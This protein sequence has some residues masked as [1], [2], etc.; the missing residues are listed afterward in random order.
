M[1]T[2]APQRTVGGGLDSDR[3]SVRSTDNQQKGRGTDFANSL[4]Y[5]KLELTGEAEYRNVAEGDRRKI[6]TVQ[7]AIDAH[8]EY[9]SNKENATLVLESRECND[10]MVLPYNH[11]ETEGYRDMTYAKLKRAEE[12]LEAKFGGP[13]IP[14]TWVSLTVDPT[15]SNGKPLPPGVVLDKLN[16]SRD[17]LRK[18]IHRATKEPDSVLGGVD[19]EYITVIEPQ[20]SGYPHLHTAIFGIASKKLADKIE[21]MWVEEYG[22]GERRAQNVEA[23]RGRSK[24]VRNVTQYLMKYLGKT[25]VRKGGDGQELESYKAFSALLWVTGKRQYSMSQWLSKAVSRGKGGGSPSKWRFWG[26]SY[27]GLDPGTYSGDLALDLRD[28]L[29]S[30]WIPPPVGAIPEPKEAVLGRF[31]EV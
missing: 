17:K 28:H 21:D 4:D 15:D 6:E 11:R 30:E 10:I 1:S 16:E 2:E 31:A 25:T 7:E 27:A 8:G 29:E 13:P 22:V 26:V 19:T 5:S 14:T 20:Q 3:L 18:V 24:Q 23:I 9:I 12:A